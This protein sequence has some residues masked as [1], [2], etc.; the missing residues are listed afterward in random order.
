MTIKSINEAVREVGTLLK[1]EYS[2]PIA[3]EELN[4]GRYKIITYPNEKI[5]I[6]YKR[7]HFLKYADDSHGESVNKE[8]LV[9]AINKGIKR[10]FI[11]YADNK[12]Y[13][14]SPKTILAQATVRTTEEEGKETY[15]FPLKLLIRFNGETTLG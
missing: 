13:T 7:E 14:I 6:L 9:K 15:S 5:L 4:E 2:Y 10:V 11:V 8:D 3:I 12:I 1:E